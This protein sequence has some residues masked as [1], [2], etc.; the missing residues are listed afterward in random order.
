M[1]KVLIDKV[2]AMISGVHTEERLDQSSSVSS[3]EIRY[4]YSSYSAEIRYAYYLYS[5]CNY[6]Y[7]VCCY[8]LY[9]GKVV[10]L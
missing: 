2:L 7:L 8:S 3:A 4:A 1:D 6:V 9:D 5:G 10:V